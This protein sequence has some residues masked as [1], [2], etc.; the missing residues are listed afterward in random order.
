MLNDLRMQAAAGI[1]RMPLDAYIPLHAA[2]KPCI[3][4]CQMAG[5]KNRVDM[6]E[7]PLLIFLIE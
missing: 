1:G 7:F 5:L 3:S 4:Q 6:Q 2:G